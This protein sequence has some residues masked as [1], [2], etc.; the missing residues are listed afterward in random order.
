MPLWFMVFGGT[1]PVG[2]L[3]GGVLFEWIGARW[4]LLIGAAWTLFLARWLDLRRL[5]PT[6]FLPETEG[7]EPT[8]VSVPATPQP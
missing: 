2:N 5:P 8:F 6:A 7:G 4:V 1:V 3:I